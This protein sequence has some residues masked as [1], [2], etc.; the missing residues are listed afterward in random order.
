MAPTLS[1]NYG[2]NR[3]NGVMGLRWALGGQSAISRCKT[4]LVQDTTFVSATAQQSA[5]TI[6]R[7]SSQSNLNGLDKMFC[8]DGQRLVAVSGAYGAS[9][10]E[11]RTESESFTRIISN[12]T[13]GGGPQSFTVHKKNG[14]ILQYGNVANARRAA[15][16]DS[17]TVFTWSLT[18]VADIAGNEIEFNYSLSG[19]E[20]TLTSVDYTK[21]GATDLNHSVEFDYGSSVRPDPIAGY[22]GNTAVNTLHRLEAVRVKAAGSLVRKYVVDYENNANDPLN[23]SRVESI[24]L[25]FDE[26]EN[27]CT[28]EAQFTWPSY[29]A[30]PIMAEQSATDLNEL[31][32][33]GVN[34]LTADVNGDGLTDMVG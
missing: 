7:Y 34:P 29:P 32:F 1:F 10:T 15:N 20:Q 31:W 24:G 17:S 4:T 6:G 14:Q 11:Y 18:E 19:G 2:S 21:N 8:L 33:N 13:Q 16:N 22:M 9:G 25:C 26:A 30:S 28:E 23:Q 27:D 5:G 3:G 12:G